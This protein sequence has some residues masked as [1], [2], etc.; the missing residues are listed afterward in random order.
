LYI[1]SGYLIKLERRWEMKKIFLFS[2]LLIV[3]SIASISAFWPFEKS[4]TGNVIDNTQM[5]DT[6]DC[7]DYDYGINTSKS[8]FVLLQ[9]GRWFNKKTT[10]Y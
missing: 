1:P 10:T 8:G 5:V 3:F 4:I 6:E 7:R 2:V 9:K